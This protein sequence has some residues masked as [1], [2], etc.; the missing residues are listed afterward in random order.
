MP[1]TFLF[2][3]FTVEGVLVF[4]LSCDGPWALQEGGLYVFLLPVISAGRARSNDSGW[5][6]RSAS[7]AR[8]ASNGPLL[9][10]EFFFSKKK[11]TKAQCR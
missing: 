11:A 9:P 7:T 2:A 10:E 1:I 5:M 4:F 3:D 8:R 6:V